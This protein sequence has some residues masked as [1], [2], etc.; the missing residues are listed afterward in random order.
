MDSVVDFCQRPDAEV[1]VVVGGVLV[2]ARRRKHVVVIVGIVGVEGRAIHHRRHA[3]TG[4]GRLSR[5][6][7]AYRRGRECE[8]ASIAGRA[9]D[10]RIQAAHLHIICRTSSGEVGIDN[11]AGRGVEMILRAVHVRR[12]SPASFGVTTAGCAPAGPA[13]AWRTSAAAR[14]HAL[15][16]SEQVVFESVP[17][18][19]RT[20]RAGAH[21]RRRTE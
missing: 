12:S 20:A 17:D 19:E 9:N 1:C 16:H 13:R 5:S 15:I 18:R 4:R 11:G 10:S 6:P 8:R 2:D 3:D 14:R 7:R 21:L